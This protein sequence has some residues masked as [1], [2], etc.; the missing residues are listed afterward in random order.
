[1][2]RGRGKERERGRERERER[3]REREREREREERGERGGRVRS[4]P[5]SFYQC[6]HPNLSVLAILT[7]R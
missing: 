2:K 1:M 7:A 3:G 4:C 5:R 6:L